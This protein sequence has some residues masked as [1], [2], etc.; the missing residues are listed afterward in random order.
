MSLRPKPLDKRLSYMYTYNVYIVAR[1]SGLFS[2]RVCPSFLFIL[3]LAPRASS[4]SSSG[5]GYYR[6]YISDTAD[7][8]TVCVC[9]YIHRE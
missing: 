9:V 8:P 6:A 7:I 4:S 3:S 1:D 5:R 2:Y